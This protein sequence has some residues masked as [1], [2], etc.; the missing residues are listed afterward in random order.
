MDFLLFTLREKGELANLV[1]YRGLS[2]NFAH[3]KPYPIE[4][5]TK[6]LKLVE[7]SSKF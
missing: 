1:S 6:Q 3:S 5:F 2:V 7:S 4:K